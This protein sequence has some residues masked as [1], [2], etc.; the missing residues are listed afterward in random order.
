MR[1]ILGSFHHLLFF[2]LILLL[3]VQLGKHFWPSSA[4]VWGLPIDYLAPTIYLTD[5]LVIGILLS[6]GISK[7]KFQSS[8]LK[9]TTQNSKPTY[10]LFIFFGFLLLNVFLAR[11]R[12]V[13]FYQWVK[14]L[15][16]IFL[17]LYVARNRHTL[18]II[19]YSLF[20]PIIYSSLL[21]IGQFLNR[22]SL[23][24]W[25]WWLGERTFGLGT[26]G[27]ARASFGGRLMLRPYATFPHP[28]VLAGF[29]LVSLVL[30]VLKKRRRG[31]FFWLSFLLGIT[32]IFLSY[33]RVVWLAGAGAGLFFLAKKFRSRRV[34][35]LSFL[36]LLLLLT[37]LFLS[38]S[39]DSLSILRR[40]N[41]GQ[42]AILM[43]K[44]RP[45]FGIGLGN[46]LVRL[47][48]FWQEKE[49]IRFF[50]PV[51][52]LFLLVAAETGLAGLGIFLWFLYRTTARLMK[53]R[54]TVLFF[55]LLVI[56]FTG[57][58]DHYWLTLQQSQLLF[59]I[60]LGLSWQE[61][62]RV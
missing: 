59:A 27:I 56:F 17:G 10:L 22:G 62:K 41:L 57:L 58:F 37:W 45:F 21:A 19:Y 55:C 29:L 52:N 5:L 40:L 26:P 1:R 44:K 34:I 38:F 53:Q 11:S 61:K 8:K 23:G 31:F 48:E 12:G 7:L 6:W 49:G 47:V 36:L 2:F 43:F 14:V 24:G 28:N 16:F 30:V 4:F 51:H 33:S 50:Q 35:T 20:I 3:P 13:A 54:K 15:E 25:L 9:T 18:F 42:A 32:A 46:Y 60:V 39:F